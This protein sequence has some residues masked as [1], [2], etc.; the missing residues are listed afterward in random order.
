MSINVGQQWFNKPA[1]L[2]ALR[3]ITPV[4][5]RNLGVRFEKKVIDLVFSCCEEM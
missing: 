4:L 3:T 5:D 2:E 1:V